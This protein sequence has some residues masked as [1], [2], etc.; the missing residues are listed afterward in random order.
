[1]AQHTTHDAADVSQ[2]HDDLWY[3]KIWAVLLGLLVVSV[4]GPMADIPLLT[5]ITAF[6]IAGVKGYLV[7]KHFMHINL[8]PRYVGYVLVT[9]IAL[10]VLFFG[11]TAPD[12]LR[13]DGHQWTNLAAQ[14]E[15]QRALASEGHGSAH[16]VAT[17]APAAPAASAAPA[18]P[19]EP[20]APDAAFAAV[21]A[22]CHGAEGDGS[23]P[24]AQALNPKPA[25]FRAAEFWQSRDVSHI[26]KVIR[27]GGAAVGRSPLM[28]AFGS[29]FDEQ[30]AR[31]LADYL[32]TR[33]RPQ[34]AAEPAEAPAEP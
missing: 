3:V 19:A 31:S 8:E 27:E 12:V 11:G 15:V 14:A 30:A 6:G 33:F 34:Q 1:M 29:Q 22:S 23:G 32:S 25:N 17:A 2:G 20:L 28:P 9:C 26:A 18:A 13:H 16:A 10:M 4:I 21:C 7:A 5:L 24:A